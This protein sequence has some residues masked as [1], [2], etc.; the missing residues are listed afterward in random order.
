MSSLFMYHTLRIMFDVSDSNSIG[1]GLCVGISQ[2]SVSQQSWQWSPDQSPATYTSSEDMQFLKDRLADLKQMMN[3]LVAG[4]LAEVSDKFDG[5]E[6]KK[7]SCCSPLCSIFV[8]MA[9]YV[10]LFVT[11]ESTRKNMGRSFPSGLDRMWTH[12][13]ALSQ[14]QVRPCRSPEHA[15]QKVWTL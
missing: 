10:V 14:W 4:H 6:F 3:V 8:I 2:Q 13:I 1:N 11:R 5:P 12:L 9:H 15:R 7:V